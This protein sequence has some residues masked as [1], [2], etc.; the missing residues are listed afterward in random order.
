MALHK[1]WMGG[2]IA[3]AIVL[4]VP[5]IAGAA[6]EAASKAAFLEAYK[7]FMHP[8]CMNCHPKGDIPL[9]GDDSHLHTQNV[10]RGVSGRGKYAMR[11]SNCHQPTNVPGENMPPGNAN[12]R[13]PP[14]EMRMVFQGRTPGELA[15]QL[16][17]PTLNGGKSLEQIYE[18]VAHDDLVAW[19]W[20]PGDGR[21]P[22]PLGHEEFAQKV[23]VWIDN[24]AAEPE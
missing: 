9:Q 13:L 11:C 23:R 24:G 8:R 1:Q 18:H 16:K 7:V 14:P 10:Q 6:D 5:L 4:A 21:D 2:L 19:G 20:N 17:D 3:P 12:W 15:R 22:P